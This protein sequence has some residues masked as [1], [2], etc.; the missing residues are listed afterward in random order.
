LSLWLLVK[1]K[2]DVEKQRSDRI[3]RHN[4]IAGMVAAGRETRHFRVAEWKQ[5]SLTPADL[6]IEGISR[7][8][9]SGGSLF[10]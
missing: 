3:P 9:E 5:S 1:K 6:G 8:E 7:A 2:D 10:A 4:S